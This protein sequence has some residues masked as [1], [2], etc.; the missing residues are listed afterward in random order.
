MA[1]VMQFL[2]KIHKVWAIV[3]SLFY[4]IDAIENALHNA[5]SV[6]FTID[7]GVAKA[8]FEVAIEA[9]REIDPDD[10]TGSLADEVGE[11]VSDIGRA[12][13]GGGGDTENGAAENVY[14]E[15][16]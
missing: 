3:K 5:E 15:P 4:R 2:F 12:L 8:N 10:E 7:L 9:D 11:I 13:T 14:P 6:P 16:R 1:N